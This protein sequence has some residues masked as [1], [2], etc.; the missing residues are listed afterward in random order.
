MHI[1]SYYKS[2]FRTPN[3]FEL[4]PA[5]KKKRK[6]SFDRAQKPTFRMSGSKTFVV[7]TEPREN[8]T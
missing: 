8:W 1:K 3:W 2:Q 4:F 5:K 7:T 6:K